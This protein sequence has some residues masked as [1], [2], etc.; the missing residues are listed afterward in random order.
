MASAGTEYA[1][2]FVAPKGRCRL[3][4]PHAPLLDRIARARP[5]AK[6]WGPTRGRSV[7]STPGRAFRL[8]GGSSKKW[9]EALLNDKSCSHPGEFG[10]RPDASAA[11]DHSQERLGEANGLLYFSCTEGTPYLHGSG[12]HL[13]WPRQR[14]ES[15]VKG[16]SPSSPTR[17]TQRHFRF[18]GDRGLW[19]GTSQGLGLSPGLS[20]GHGLS[21]YSN[22]A[23]QVLGQQ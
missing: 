21:D 11:A 12:Y 7:A 23:G 8:L 18:L 14:V 16:L 9:R 13:V 10:G 4:R 1:G 6:A 19:R 22:G 17:Q 5:E 15:G 20:P 2:P 3:P